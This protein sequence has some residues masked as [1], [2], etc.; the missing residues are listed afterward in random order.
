MS[1]KPGPGM[2]SIRGLVIGFP[3]SAGA[4]RVVDD[5]DLEIG[6]GEIH[7]LVGES[8]SGKTLLA[9]S[10][11]DLLPPGAE[12]VEGS[13]L[14]Q[15]R[16]LAGLD[17][18]EMRK[19]RGPGIGMVFQ[20]PM[21]SLNP[22]LKIGRQLTEALQ[23]H[24]GCDDVVARARAVE[25][26]ERVRM[27]D[28]ARCL[29]AYPHQFSGGMRQRIMLASVLMLEPALLIADEPTTALDV[30]IQKEVLEIMLGIVRE[31]GTAV[32]LITHDLGLVARYATRL[33]VM[34]RG[35]VMEAGDVDQVL[36]RPS[37]PY[38][39]R[40]LE[41]LPRRI[42]DSPQAPSGSPLVEVKNL[43]VAYRQPSPWPWRRPREVRAVDG[44]SL[45]IYRNETVAVVGESGSGK[46]TLGRAIIGLVP[47]TEGS[48]E[49]EGKQVDALPDLARREAMRRAQIIFQ[50]PYSSLNPRKRI[51]SIIGEGLRYEQGLVREE[52]DLRVARMLDAVGLD[53][54]WRNRF[55][56]E[57]SGGQRQRVGIARAVITRPRL[58]VADESVS[59]LDLTVQ[60]Q[61]LKLLKDLQH[62]MGFS[63]LFISHD[64]GVVEQVADRI[65][66]MYRGAIVE[67]GSRDDIFDRP[68]HPYTRALLGAICELAPSGEGGY[69]L[70]ER[71]RECLPSPRGFGPDRR[72]LGDVAAPV[73]LRELAPGHLVA[74]SPLE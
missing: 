13:I 73:E 36:A 20:E 2:L 47:R 37:H 74:C 71:R 63:Y 27:P 4:T 56:H 7:G 12:V 29:D 1:G 9:R 67:L 61:V 44:V 57:L 66:V 21:M 33:T 11:L 62:R 54:A 18:G 49:F 15:G 22:A 14:F 32:L 53:P 51:G 26:L 52:R 25:M 41:A 72:Y 6:A 16:E 38:T 17:R 34:E 24:L 65:A 64:L 35:R 43:R 68:G 40:L 60:A 5:A 48:I 8:G 70:R 28:P 69:R 31:L 3:R 39:R 55:P 59:A 45:E 19:L 10:I 23:L 30:L 58:V 46:T 50:D 42:D